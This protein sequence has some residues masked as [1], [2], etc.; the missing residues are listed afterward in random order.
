MLVGG[1]STVAQRSIGDVIDDGLITAKVKSSFAADPQ[2]S[3]LAINVDTADG[4]VSLTGVVSSEGERQRAVQLAQGI[5]GV[6]RVDAQNLRLRRAG[7]GA[8]RGGEHAMT[9]TITAINYNTGILG[10]RT[11]PGELTLHFPPPAVKEL[12]EGETITVHFAFER[13]A[14]ER[15]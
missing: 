12:Q 10:L 13:G 15:R 6:K 9:G 1:T 2:V 4:V 5:E 7:T 3:A 8:S 11:G 14:T